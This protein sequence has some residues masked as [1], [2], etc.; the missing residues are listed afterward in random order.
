MRATPRFVVT[1]LGLL[2]ACT[3]TAVTQ[4]DGAAAAA[5]A[6][7]GNGAMSPRKPSVAAQTDFRRQFVEVAKVVRPSVVA[8]TSV[9]AVTAPESPFEGSPFDFFFRGNPRPQ[10]KQ[11]RQGMGSGVIV[12][13]RGYI[14]TNNHV[15]QGADTLTV[16]L[17]DD[18]ELPAQ[19]VGTDPK[20]DVAVIKVKLEGKETG[21]LTPVALGNSDQL[22]VGEWVMAIGSPFGLKQTVSAG[23]VSAVGRG[24]MGITDYED[25]VQTDAA[26]NPGNSGGPLVDLEGRVVA[27]NTA[28]A[29]RSGGNQGVGFAIPVNMAKAVM[30]QLIDHGSVVR[31]YLGVFI[32]DV[33]PEL[34]KSFGYT[35]RGGVLV[36]DVTAGSPGA[37]AGL[38]AGDILVER[39][40]KPIAELSSFRN[41]IAATA[42][43]TSIALTVYRDGKRVALTAKLEALPGDEAQAKAGQKEP[44]GGQFAH[45][46]ALA[47]LTPEIARRF[48]IEGKSGVVVVKVASGSSA[49]EAGLRQG[50]LITQIGRAEI[51]TLKDAERVLGSA[52]AKTPLRLRVV[53]EGHGLFVILKP[54]SK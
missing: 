34:G 2:L 31:G 22:E 3:S 16:V 37:K 8:I 4:R 5:A 42:P 44:S 26:I 30:D 32:A 25:F 14:L 36:Q 53:R 48:E 29:S 52:D 6:A 19:V 40:G 12:D 50:D 27:I 13:A 33:S 38:R 35:G 10:G 18:R 45:G 43:G 46:L 17:H 54:A 39:D 51:K 21:A 7:G 15:V 1:T 23:I 49:D 41:G 20:T 11:K 47:E 9:A 24:H 28:I